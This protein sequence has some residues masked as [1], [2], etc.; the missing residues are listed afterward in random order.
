M[1]LKLKGRKDP[2][3]FGINILRLEIEYKHKL[4]EED[5]VIALVRRVGTKYANTIFN[6]TRMIESNDKKFIC[7][8]LLTVLHIS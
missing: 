7:E 2:D 3:K 1:V 5:K 6:E 4:T 8:A